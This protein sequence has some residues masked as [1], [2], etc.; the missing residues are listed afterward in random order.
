MLLIGGLYLAEPGAPTPRPVPAAAARGV[1]PGNQAPQAL[2]AT[3]LAESPPQSS[4][5]ERWRYTGVLQGDGGLQYAFHLI[6]RKPGGSAA[7]YVYEAAL[8]Q[9]NGS[10]AWREQ[11]VLPAVAPPASGKGFAFALPEGQL[12][13]EAGR[14]GMALSFNG[15]QL[16]LTLSDPEPALALPALTLPEHAS[17]LQGFVRPR[18]Q[19]SGSVSTE[20]VAQSLRGEV[21]FERQWGNLDLSAYRVISFAL[22]L[23]NGAAAQVWQ[24]ADASSRVL[25]NAGVWMQGG[26][27]T[28]LADSAIQVLATGS[29]RSPSTGVTFPM[30]WQLALPGQGVRARVQPVIRHSLFNAQ[31]SGGGVYWLGAVELAGAPG[32][33]GFV[34]MSG[35]PVAAAG[36]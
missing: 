19:V 35:Y 10:K 30:D 28:P 17:S 22:Q 36:R 1:V 29:W 7:G 31:P 27:V 15:V 14:H 18:M 6:L 12:T 8:A 4:P 34:E 11:G 16:A 32:G 2:P 9:T 25:L 3:V 5:F 26:G 33:R 24:V 21:W 20:G 23:A 13:A